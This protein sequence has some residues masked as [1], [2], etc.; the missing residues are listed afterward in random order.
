[1]ATI[2]LVVSIISAVAAVA[3]VILAWVGIRISRRASS[4][5]EASAA[6]ARRSA[7]ADE[8]I[9]RIEQRRQYEEQRPALEGRVVPLATQRDDGFH[10]QLDVWLTTPEPLMWVTLHV[11]ANR[12]FYRGSALMRFDLSYP[13]GERR[14]PIKTRE[15]ISWPVSLSETA[16]GT[17]VVTA[18]CR[19]DDAVHYEGIEVLID[20]DAAETRQRHARLS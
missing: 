15:V 14:L 3:A 17:V 19:T 4:A 20:L 8:G 12:G 7:N 1:M 2:A 10:F 16:H 9:H 6:E 11:P 5:A 13:I 18:E